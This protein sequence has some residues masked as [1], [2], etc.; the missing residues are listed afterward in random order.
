MVT[1][2]AQTIELPVSR[3]PR[4]G[5][6]VL[7]PT[8]RLGCCGDECSACPRYRATLHGD[9]KQL[10]EIAWW[11]YAFG[12]REQVLPPEE[13]CCTGCSKD[14]PCTHGIARCAA[15]KRISHCG[16]C[17][18]YP[19]ERL[20]KALDGTDAQKERLRQACPPDLFAKVEKAFLRKRENLEMLRSPVAAKAS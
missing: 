6:T 12:W 18:E 17:Q 5:L 10:G 20:V 1:T 8:T 16:Q 4:R 13:F 14:T 2:L 7:Q 19:C 9:M 3:E 11:W 15:A